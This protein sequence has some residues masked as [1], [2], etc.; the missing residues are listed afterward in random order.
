MD[1]QL[2]DII[3]AIYDCVG[4]EELWPQALKM[5]GDEVEGYLTTLA[6]FDTNTKAT[7]LA[8]IACDDQL[9]IDALHQ[10]AKHVP[11][12][13]LL[14]EME[15][16]HPATLDRMFTLYGP[17]GEEVW[18]QGELYRNF[19]EKFGIANSIDMAVL[20]RPSR[21]GTIN[22]SVKYEPEEP[23]TFE[24]I[25]L[26][27]PHIRRAVT[28][29]DMFEMQRSES[30][31]LRDVI[32]ALEHGVVIVSD[33]MTIIYANKAAEARLH[34]GSII[35][36]SVRKFAARYQPAQVALSR[37]IAIGGRSE[38]S[39]A[40]AG[41]D[42][43]LSAVDRPAVAHILPL[44]RRSEKGRIESNAAAAIFIAASG[45]VIQT[46]VEAIA[47][48]F[49]LTPTEK[50]IIAYVSG[51]LNRAEIAQAQGVADGTVKAQLSAIFDKTGAFDQRSLERLIQ[52]LTPPVLRS[53][54]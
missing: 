20:K 44:E 28:I 13:H 49:G 7:R 52:E 18:K 37:A 29:H 50:R 3:G 36:S 45:V 8:Q 54:P 2:S 53:K 33:D 32:D 48:L 43:P 25:G 24:V 51:G 16:D 41:I 39:L 17:D 9:A 23:R 4:H 47:A 30:L 21:V 15:I 40:G 11:F 22:I 6:V 14:H 12:F 31:A 26:L 19:H 42:V 35:Y 34:D 27:G 38:V 46:A 5:I 1:Q 10:H